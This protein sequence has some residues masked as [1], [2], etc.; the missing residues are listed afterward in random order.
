LC[1][2]YCG[3]KHKKERYKFIDIF[4]L[5]FP[6]QLMFFHYINIF[7]VSIYKYSIWFFMCLCLYRLKFK[8]RFIVIF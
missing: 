7:W 4:H 1:W 2:I 8:T 3:R 6:L 5:F